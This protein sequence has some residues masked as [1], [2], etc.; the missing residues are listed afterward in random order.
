MRELTKDQTV[1]WRAIAKSVI[2]F[3]QT[4]TEVKDLIPLLQ[5][6]MSHMLDQA[7]VVR[8]SNLP[9]N[10][11]IEIEM[12]AD[13][14]EK[15]GNRIL[16]CSQF[17]ADSPEKISTDANTFGEIFYVHGKVDRTKLPKSGASAIPVAEIISLQD[18]EQEVQV[19]S[20]HYEFW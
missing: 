4:K 12:L 18:P 15:H 7:V 10:A 13:A 11:L 19:C 6:D 5:K 9:M 14:G 20:R 16:T 2:V 1:D 8:V 17:F 3:I